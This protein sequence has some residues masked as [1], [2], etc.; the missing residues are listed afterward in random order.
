MSCISVVKET[1][2]RSMDSNLIDNMVYKQ[3]VSVDRCT[4]ETISKSADDFVD[5]FCETLETL[6]PHSFIANSKPVSIHN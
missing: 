6:L 5:L 3:W 2:T 1:L 4:L